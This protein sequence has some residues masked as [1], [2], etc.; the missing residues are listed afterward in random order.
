MDEVN[1]PGT[2]KAK[3]FPFSNYCNN[4]L[5]N[6]FCRLDIQLWDFSDVLNETTITADKDKETIV[7]EVLSAIE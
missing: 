4:Q 2:K 3:V 6:I 7:Q 5:L 1:K